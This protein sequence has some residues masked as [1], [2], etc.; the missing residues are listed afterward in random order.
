MRYRLPKAHDERNATVAIVRPHS[1]NRTNERPPPTDIL[2]AAIR[3]RVLI[4]TFPVPGHITAF[5]QTLTNS[6][7]QFSA[8]PYSHLTRASLAPPKLATTTR[9]ACPPFR[10]SVSP[11]NQTLSSS[12]PC[13]PRRTHR[14]TTPI[15]NRHGHTTKLLL[16]PQPPPHPI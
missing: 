1:S 11:L 4:L 14:F 9:L 8:A 12:C 16:K 7:Q 2:L 10:S 6:Q 13:V 15:V 3:R 5:S